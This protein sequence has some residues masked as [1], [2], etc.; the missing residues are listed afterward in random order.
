MPPTD[1][2]RGLAANASD[3]RE[4]HN[5]DLTEVVQRENRGHPLTIDKGSRREVAETALAFVKRFA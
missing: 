1:G 4:R 3:K 2:N 5:P